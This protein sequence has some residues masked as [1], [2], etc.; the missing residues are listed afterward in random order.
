MANSILTPSIIAKEM[1]MAFKNA[2]TFTKNADRQYS[3][4]FAK[5]GAKIGNTVTV[6]KPARFTVRTGPALN[7]QNVTEEFTTLVLN[8][9]KG[10]DFLFSTQ[11]LTLSIDD[12][13]ARY[14]DE[15]IVALA[16]QVDV[17]GL[18]MATQN[19]Y[20]A[21]GTPGTTPA[22]ALL[23]MQGQQ[24]LNELAA[25]KD[26]KRSMLINPA[27]E[28]VIVDAL[29]GLFQSSERIAEQYDTGMMGRGLGADWYQ[30][31]NIVNTTVGV[32]TGTPL[33]NGASQTGSTLACDGWT[34]STAGILNQGDIFTIA[35]VYKVNP[36]S[37]QSTGVLQ[38]FVVTATAAS[39]A[40]TGPIAALG[41]SPAIITS[42]PTQTVNASPAD[43]AAITVVGTGGT[44]TANNLLY[45]KKAFTLGCADME[46]PEGVHF[47][48]RA[49]DPESGLSIRIVR[50]YDINSDTIPCRL[51]ILYGWAALR[52]EWACR[53]LG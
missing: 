27:A 48:A 5:T 17:D 7:V 9:Q 22:T 2:T 32:A 3:K 33:V 21:V 24:K 39:G 19:T 42:G 49:T 51:D 12:F 18:T 25:P 28:P 38:Q 29:K 4:E 50:Q 52:Q 26:G 13:R 35:N 43:N 34:N 23:Y 36:I 37:K 1:L 44:L 14:I 16:N 11:D 30:T 46:M 10:V 45:H 53:V 41:I 47:A 6:R 20:N 31:Q 15:A 8:N 40:S